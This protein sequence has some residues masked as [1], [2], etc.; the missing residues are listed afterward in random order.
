MAPWVF[1]GPGPA[2]AGQD[3]AGGDGFSAGVE[4]GKIVILARL[5]GA[6]TPETIKALSG[7]SPVTFTFVAQVKRKR[8]MIWDGTARQVVLKRIVKYDALKKT[9]LA[10]EKRDDTRPEDEINFSEE[11]KRVEYKPSEPAKNN[12]AVAAQPPADPSV[13]VVKDNKP[14]VMDPLIFPSVKEMEEWVSSTGRTELGPVE[15]LGA[16]GDYYVQVRLK[17]KSVNPSPPLRYILFFLSFLD[18]DTGW[19]RSEQF[20][21]SPAQ[22]ESALPS[23]GQKPSGAAEPA[24]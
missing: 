13:A 12:A 3:S 22:K 4:N 7:G 18:F 11:L 20:N 5:Q 15:G 14:V 23:A 10:W 21:V 6:L 1:I 16:A 2:L 19:L 17:V 9:Y 24:K 8:F